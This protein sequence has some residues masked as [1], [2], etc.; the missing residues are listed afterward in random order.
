MNLDQFKDQ[1]ILLGVTDD[2]E[3]ITKMSPVLQ[4]AEK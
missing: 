3:K 2:V 4:K 1:K